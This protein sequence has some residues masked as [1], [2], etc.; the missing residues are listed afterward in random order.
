MELVHDEL[1]KVFLPTGDDIPYMRQAGESA[2]HCLKHKRRN[3]YHHQ[4]NR[5]KRG[6]VHSVWWVP[7][8]EGNDLTIVCVGF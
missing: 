3:V 5:D 6:F 1:R 4:I 2:R 7:R 8:R